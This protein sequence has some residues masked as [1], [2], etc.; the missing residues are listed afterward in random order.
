MDDR[1]GYLITLRSYQ[2]VCSPFGLPTI[3]ERTPSVSWAL[4]NCLSPPRVSLIEA[5]LPW[6]RPRPQWLPLLGGRGGHR[7]QRVGG[8][9]ILTDSH[10]VRRFGHAASVAREVLDVQARVPP[11]FVMVRPHVAYQGA[12]VRTR[13]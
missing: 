11:G 1:F 4:L 7:G 12:D 6:V 13:E 8:G 5:G 9:V 10:N 3:S 2:P